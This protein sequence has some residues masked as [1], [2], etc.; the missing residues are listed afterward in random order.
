MSFDGCVGTFMNNSGLEDVMKSKLGLAHI[1]QGKNFPQNMR[2]IPKVTKVI[3]RSS[4]AKVKRY[5][6]IISLFE[7]RVS[8][9][10]TKRL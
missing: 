5:D 2:A 10:Q 6:E 1:G 3:L 8:C 9:S 4:I 7:E